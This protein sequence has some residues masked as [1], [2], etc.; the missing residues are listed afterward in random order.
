M[1][2]VTTL[3]CCPYS[4]KAATEKSKQMGMA[5]FQQNLTYKNRHQTGFGPRAA[6]CQPL[7]KYTPVT[8]TE[9]LHTLSH[10]TVQ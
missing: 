1:V 2:S 8:M 9:A 5:V 7:S 6:V 10:E 4:A 3:Q